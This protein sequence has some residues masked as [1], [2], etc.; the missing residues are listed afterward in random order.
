MRYLIIL[1]IFYCTH[2]SAE[3]TPLT[4]IG[5]IESVKI[6]PEGLELEAKIDT[7]A[8]NSS[9][10]ITDWQKLNRDGNPWIRFTV[11]NN[12][13]HTQVFE[14]PLERYTRIKRKGTEPLKRPVVNMLICIGN[15]QFLTP[16]NLA[17]RKNFKYRMLI[18]RSF[19]KQRFLV[20]SASKL[21]T[22][23]NCESEQ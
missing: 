10:D 18:G 22:S 11:I 5:W 17:K 19:L 6:L 15:Q 4:T 1:F 14:R 7:G 16:V 9:L 8:D 23:P 12:S 2:A 13:G 20:D 3:N 21:T